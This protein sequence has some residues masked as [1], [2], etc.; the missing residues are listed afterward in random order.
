MNTAN[1]GYMNHQPDAVNDIFR[2]YLVIVI[3]QTIVIS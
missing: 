2:R 3:M 1:K